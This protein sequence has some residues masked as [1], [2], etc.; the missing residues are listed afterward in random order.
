[1]HSQGRDFSITPWQLQTEYSP[2]RMWLSRRSVAN[3]SLNTTVY[4][5]VL[6]SSNFLG[7]ANNHS[8]QGRNKI[9]DEARRK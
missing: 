5:N 6:Y 9:T 2:R 4:N 1:M 8:T 7:K 3:N